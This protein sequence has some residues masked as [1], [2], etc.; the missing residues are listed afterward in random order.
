LLRWYRLTARPLLTPRRMR[1]GK[2]RAS[3]RSLTGRARRKHEVKVCRRG[4]PRP[5]PLLMREAA[6]DVR[7]ELGPEVSHEPS[8]DCT[9]LT[10]HELLPCS[11]G[12]RQPGVFNGIAGDRSNVAPP[13]GSDVAV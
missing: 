9:R 10:Q 8:A 13:R 7:P 2:R 5:A 1:K 6:P 4:S 3:C 12:R 11:C